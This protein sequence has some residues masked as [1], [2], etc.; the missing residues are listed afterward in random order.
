MILRQQ[1]FLR[2]M[3]EQLHPRNAFVLVVDMDAQPGKAA[4]GAFRGN[5]RFLPWKNEKDVN[6]PCFLGGGGQISIC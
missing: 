6:V 3:H 2:A 1:E 5:P 4:R